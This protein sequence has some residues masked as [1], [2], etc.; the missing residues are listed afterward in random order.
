[1]EKLFRENGLKIEVETNVTMTNYL[2]IHFD[3]QKG[4][5]RPYKKDEPL[6]V[7][8]ASNH[9]KSVIKAIPE[10]V[11]RRISKLSSSKKI[12]EEESESYQEILK[13][14]GYNYKMEYRPP[15]AKEK[16]KSRARRVTYFNPPFSNTVKTNVGKE[17]F[18]IMEE[19]F[20]KSHA[21]SKFFNKNTLKISYSTCKNM[22]GYLD[23]HNRK[24][25]NSNKRNDPPC[26]CEEPCPL[27]GKCGAKDIVYGANVTALD[28][29]LMM[30]YYG[31]TS[32]EFKRTGPRGGKYGRYY[33]HL[34]AIENEESTHSTK[35][36]NY[37]WKLK[38][39][40]RPYKIDWFIQSRAPETTSSS[41]KCMLCIKEKTAIARHED[42]NT[43]LNSRTEILSKCIHR[44][45]F[46]LRRQ[47]RPP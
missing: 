27:D 35:L 19:C 14:C 28:N 7:N 40:G 21:L 44:N 5:H 32:R 3:L 31:L 46:E 25:L 30:T 29:Y 26:Q 37:V 34:H 20:P 22:K 18:A 42:C 6:Y 13:Q 43:L 45:S 24:V 10:T 36:S 11:N 2:D 9:P 17:F 12:F 39:A 23:S 1:M 33:E 15:Q 4:E 16:K 41:K 47:K 38:K 8:A